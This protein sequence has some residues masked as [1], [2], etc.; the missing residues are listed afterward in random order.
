LPI[1]KPHNQ[2]IRSCNTSSHRQYFRQERQ[3]I[4]LLSKWLNYKMDIM[5]KEQNFDFSVMIEYRQQAVNLCMASIMD[6]LRKYSIEAAILLEEVWNKTFGFMEFVM[7]LLGRAQA[8]Q[9]KTISS[10]KTQL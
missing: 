6:T 2:A 5:R 8:T 10:L 3:D 7:D 9:N 4:G 1:S